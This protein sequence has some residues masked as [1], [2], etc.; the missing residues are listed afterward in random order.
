LIVAVCVTD[1]LVAVMV[2]FPL[3]GVGFEPD[4]PLPP[5][6]PHET[7][8]NITHNKSNPKKAFREARAARRLRNGF[9]VKTIP[10]AN[11]NVA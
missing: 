10:S 5:P 9:S 3:S 7:A 8:P 11:M 4:D 6:P 2:T 1:S